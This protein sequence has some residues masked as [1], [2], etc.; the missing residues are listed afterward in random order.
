VSLPKKAKSNQSKKIPI[1]ITVLGIILAGI[2]GALSG[3]YSS[4]IFSNLGSIFVILRSSILF[5]AGIFSFLLAYGLWKGAKWGWW[6]GITVSIALILTIIVLNFLCFILGIIIFY[7]LIRQK[8]R[9]YFNMFSAQSAMEYLMTYGWAILIIAIVLGSLFSLGVFSSSSLLGNACVAQSGFTCQTPVYNHQTG[10]IIVN[11]GQETYSNWLSA[12]FVFVPQSVP[13]AA[14][15]IPSISFVSN[16]A[17][18]F[19]QMGGL[20][21]GQIVTVTLPVSNVTSIP[22][23][24]GTSTVGTVWAYYTLLGPNAQP[25]VQYVKIAS[26]SIKAS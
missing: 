22:V 2:I 19:Y 23:R 24:V 11:I 25:L 9:K 18:T 5:I 4:I 26:I 14:N 17:N 8:T 12:T 15:G 7:Y 21:S 10:N 3:T 13:Y 20:Q 1:G 6:L 16:P